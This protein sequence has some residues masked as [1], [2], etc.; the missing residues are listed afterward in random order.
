[1]SGTHLLRLFGGIY[2]AVGSWR[3]TRGTRPHQYAARLPARRGCSAAGRVAVSRAPSRSLKQCRDTGGDLGMWVCCPARPPKGHL[4]A[5]GTYQRAK[6]F[7]RDI[8]GDCVTGWR[9]PSRGAAFSSRTDP[10]RPV[11]L[12]K[13]MMQD[14]DVCLQRIQS[15]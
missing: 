6:D 8:A 3:L 10:P 11:D 2:C 12:P 7:T 15:R 13:G 1:M 14:D 9:L 4:P 5:T